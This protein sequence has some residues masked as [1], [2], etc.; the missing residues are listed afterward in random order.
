MD[1]RRDNESF[2]EQGELVDAQGNPIELDDSNRSRKAYVGVNGYESLDEI[3]SLEKFFSCLPYLIQIGGD[4]SD[5][6]T[7]LHSLGRRYTILPIDED[8]FIINANARLIEVPASFAKNGVGVQGDELCEVLYFEIDRYFDAMDLDTADIYIEWTRPDGESGV[9]KPWVID[10]ESKP[11]KIIF[12]WA[13]S[14]SITKEVGALKFAVRF[15]KWSDGEHS[16]LVYSW[17]TQAQTVTIK[18]T[19]DFTLGSDNY[20][21]ELDTDETILGRIKNCHTYVTENEVALDPGFIF[22]L[23]NNIIKR[24]NSFGQ[25]EDQQAG[26]QS[27]GFV[28]IDLIED[29]VNHTETYP[30]KVQAYSPD[31]GTISYNW[32]KKGQEGTF[33]GTSADPTHS[34][35]DSSVFV[36]TTDETIVNH[37]VYYQKVGNA[38]LAYTIP[39]TEI[40]A[41]ETPASKNLY[42]RFSVCTINQVGQYHAI[43]TN[44]VNKKNSSFADSQ[45]CVVPMPVEPTIETQ[46]SEYQIIPEETGEE[47]KVIL[48]VEA[49]N[50]ETNGSNKGTLS[51]TWWY[52]EDETDAAYQQIELE[53]PTDTLEIIDGEALPGITYK[54]GRTPT[55][56]GY[57]MVKVNNH[58]NMQDT[59]VDSIACHVSYKAKAPVLSF[60]TGVKDPVTDIPDTQIVFGNPVYVTVDSNW[61]DIHNNTEGFSYQWYKTTDQTNDDPSNDVLIEGATAATYTPTERAMYYCVVTNHKNNTTAETVSRIFS[62]A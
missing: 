33:L 35:V 38:Y 1:F 24:E 27:D 21:A 3:S 40:E 32:V 20:L 5:E 50:I 25:L 62:V 14:S 7:K 54:E 53:N 59:S 19:L 49:S 30:L 17:A 45:E 8:N 42:E 34:V 41:G 9:S 12:G 22:N 51:Y 37:K 44:R 6:Y 28:Y 11:N 56:E 60:P 39:A 18:S 48:T 2:N 55:L 43:A 31:A 61:S 16:K 57:Y 47:N 15:F 10:I 36:E 29:P 52:K 46:I 26:V 13:L 23:E 4:T 58:K